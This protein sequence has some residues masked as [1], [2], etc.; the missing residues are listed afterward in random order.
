MIDNDNLATSF[1]FLR[2]N[3][4]TALHFE[5]GIFRAEEVLICDFTIFYH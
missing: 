4:F 2:A 1:Y 3:K 5:A